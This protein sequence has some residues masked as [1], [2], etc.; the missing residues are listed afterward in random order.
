[1]ICFIAVQTKQTTYTIYLNTSI[2]LV[3]SK[4]NTFC[5]MTLT[6]Q[7]DLTWPNALNKK[8]YSGKG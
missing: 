1:M 7:P 5:F 6:Q 4:S 2:L 8:Q 3:K